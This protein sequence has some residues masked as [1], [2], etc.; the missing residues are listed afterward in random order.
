MEWDRRDN[1]KEGEKAPFTYSAT[2]EGICKELDHADMAVLSGMFRRWA[3]YDPSLTPEERT[4]FIQHSADFER[5]AA[6]G[7]RGLGR[8]RSVLRARTCCGFWQTL[9]GGIPM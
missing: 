6:M 1:R 7:R 5:I 2:V 8:G 3:L 4:R 9:S